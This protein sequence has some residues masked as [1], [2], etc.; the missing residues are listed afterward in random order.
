MSWQ[1]YIDSN[2]D[3]LSGKPIFKGTRISIEFIFDLLSKG[4]TKEQI[5]EN[6]HS[7]SKESLNA[8]F[9]FVIDVIKDESLY[10]IRKDAA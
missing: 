10:F 2:P 9:L 1:N 8:A 3:I 5:L 6:Y 7:L 4:W